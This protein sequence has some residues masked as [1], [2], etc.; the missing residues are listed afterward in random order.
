MI[1]LENKILQRI[2]LHKSGRSVGITS[3]C[4]ANHYVIKAAILNA[5]KNNQILLIEAT[6]NQVDQFGG[7][8]GL[9]P[10]QFKHS[11]FE[12][13]AS[14]NFPEDKIILGGDHLGPNRWQ[15]E[16]STSAIQKAQDQIA[17]YVSA[18]FTKIHLGC[19][20]EMC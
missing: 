12:F 17:A 2:N 7:Y 9:T 1:A 11:V 15:N 4:S 18:G 14:L 19:K 8:T 6:S 16:V 10:L 13:A 20:Y 3:V 5:K